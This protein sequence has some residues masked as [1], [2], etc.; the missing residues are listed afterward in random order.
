MATQNRWLMSGLDPTHK[1]SR[2]ANYVVS[3]R[4]ELL[5]LSRACGVEHPAMITTDHFEILD[6]CYKARSATECFGYAANRS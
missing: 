5:Q 2:F 4:K 1:A 6:E 3:L